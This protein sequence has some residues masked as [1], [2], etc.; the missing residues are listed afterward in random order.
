MRVTRLALIGLWA[1]VGCGPFEF[2]PPTDPDPG[3]VC[4]ADRD[5][6]PDACCGR[7]SRAVHRSVGPDCSEVLCDG[8][9]PEER[10][11]CGCGLVICRSNHCAVAVSEQ[12]L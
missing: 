3:P 11:D 8:Q 6:V 9:C 10:V 4:Y 7:G 1:A 5:C 2:M 12:C